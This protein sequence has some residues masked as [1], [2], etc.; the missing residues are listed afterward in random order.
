MNKGPVKDALDLEAQELVRAVR[1]RTAPLDE[2]GL[3]LV[4]RT[5]RSFNGWTDEPVTADQLR[6]IYDLMKMCP[7]AS[8]CC[9]LRLKFIQSAA[10]KKILMPIMMEANRGKIGGGSVVAILG[11]DYEFY[12][13]NAQ[14]TPFRPTAT[15]DRMIGKPDLIHHWASLNG[16]LQAAYFMLAV[17][18]AGLDIGPMQ[19]LD[20]A[21][22][23]EAFWAG[24]KV[25]TNFVCS[26]GRGDEITIFKKMPRFDFDEVCEIL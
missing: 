2:N 1:S 14:L 20:K 13:H 21:A 10:A 12:E 24:T 26:I 8:N 5:G 25:K 4:F 15:R 17:R 11:N 23:D 18:A 3:D 7:T 22:C 6:H 16:T 9:P 19:G